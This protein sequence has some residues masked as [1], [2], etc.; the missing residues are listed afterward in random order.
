[1]F[2]YNVSFQ[3]TELRKTSK[4]QEFLLNTETMLFRM[5]SGDRSS[6]K[7]SFYN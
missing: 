6:Q 4:F 7:P 5:N 1:M 2:N 3:A